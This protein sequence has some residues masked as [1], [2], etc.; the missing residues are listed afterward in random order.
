MASEA[1]RGAQVRLDGDAMQIARGTKGGRLADNL[2]AQIALNG[3]GN[4]SDGNSPDGSARN[5]MPALDEVL[6]PGGSFPGVIYG[7]LVGIYGDGVTDN[8]DAFNRAASGGPCRIILPAGIFLSRGW[9]VP[10]GVVIEGQGNTTTL[11]LLPG[12]KGHVVSSKDFDALTGTRVR[13]ATSLGAGGGTLTLTNVSL[14]VVGQTLGIADPAGNYR[15]RGTVTAFDPATKVVTLA[16]GT[17][18]YTAA[19]GDMVYFLFN[20]GPAECGVRNCYIRGNRDNTIGFDNV[21][22]PQTRTTAGSLVMNGINPAQWAD[23]KPRAAFQGNTRL[24]FESTGDN[25]MRTITI[26]G[27]QLLMR[28]GSIQT[29][30]NITLPGPGVGP[31]G[32]VMTPPDFIGLDPTTGDITIDGPVSGNI[33][34]G[35]PDGP[36]AGHGLALFGPRVIIE[37]VIAQRCRGWGIWQDW[38]LYI[39]GWDDII[40]VQRGSF[41]NVQSFLNDGGGIMFNGPLDTDASGVATCFCNHRGIEIGRR[42]LNL[43]LTFGH[44]AT[45]AYE[46]AG[47]FIRQFEGIHILADAATVISVASEGASIA[48]YNVLANNVT[49]LEVSPF[50]PNNGPFAAT[51]RAIG[52]KVGDVRAGWYTQNL[53]AHIRGFNCSG[54]LYFF[55]ASGGFNLC[56]GSGYDVGAN[57]TPTTAAAGTL[58]AAA[59]SFAAGEP[60]F[61]RNAA[62]GT[63]GKTILSV[64]GNTITFTTNIALSSP[65]FLCRGTI[66]GGT[67]HPTDIV[68]IRMISGSQERVY[69]R[70]GAMSFI[71]P[72][73]GSA[74]LLAGFLPGSTDALL[75]NRY[76]NGVLSLGANNMEVL[77][78]G[79]SAAIF[80]APIGFLGYTFS[81][82]P[83]AATSLNR[84]VRVSDRN[85]RLAT[86]DGTNWRWAGDG[87]VAS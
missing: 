52:V 45:A 34:C 10:A 57:F 63:E 64:V 74:D 83:S 8:T 29:V 67:P 78:L 51:E 71:N 38:G 20:A 18:S 72:T 86:S 33:W 44:G 28:D 69:R 14:C 22:K 12:L 24:R 81:A 80:T 56:E 79:A 25:S 17:G 77:R 58:A 2:A 47:R 19:V 9:V 35:F 37:N 41:R 27:P 50:D 70:P 85:N 66:Y 32:A 5:G 21:C 42:A 61:L 26:V 40:A 55:D 13:A 75:W 1:G 23:G 59:S 31:S 54:G 62:G 49:L 76:T 3:T 82:L 43:R 68:D 7:F 73:D 87:T 30:A 48:N 16:A 4:V 15:W 36:E 53:R 84:T 11:A 60:C 39:E 6:A 65:N 46:N